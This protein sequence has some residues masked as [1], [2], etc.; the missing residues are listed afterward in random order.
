MKLTLY[1]DVLIAVN[2]LVNY[3]LLKISAFCGQLPYKTAN[4]IASAFTGALFS[5]AVLADISAILSFVIKLF[6]VC[7]CAFI[8]Y[9]FVSF[10]YYFKSLVYLLL[11]TFIF[12]GVISL[13]TDSS[14]VYLNNCFYYININPLLLVGC[15]VAVY[16]V[17]QITALFF[18][19]KHGKDKKECEVKIGESIFNTTAFYDSGFNVKDILGHRAVMLC[20]LPAVKKQ[21]SPDFVEKTE[22]FL[23]GEIESV[24][25]IS[26][27]F[28]SDISGGGIMPAVKVEK[29]MLDKKEIK[30]TL[31]AFTGKSFPDDVGI[32]FGKDIFDMI[33]E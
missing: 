17:L 22:S 7:L 19:S 16:A 13:F 10:K 25:G 5:V 12:T 32:I 30:N 14:F 31:L 18:S 3:I 15:I 21:L 4:I 1:L 33:G 29:I 23:Q 11:S 27:V 2:F 26:H 20:S 9:G 28:Y 8:A 6:S 24:A